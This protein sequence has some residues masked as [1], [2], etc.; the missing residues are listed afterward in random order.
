MQ[1]EKLSPYIKFVVALG[2]FASSVAVGTILP[3][4]FLFFMTDVAHVSPGLAGTVLLFARL[5]D[6]VNDP[7]VGNLS[8]RTHSRWGRRRPYMLFGAVPTGILFALLWI[9]PPFGGLARGIYYL[10]TYFLFDAA[11]TVVSGPYAA[12]TP[13]LTLDADER[14]S[15]ITWRMAVSI[16]TGLAAAIVM[17]IIFSEVPNLQMGFAVVGALVGFV[18]I[19]P[20]LWIVLAVRER[21]EF[22]EQKGV[23]FLEGLGFVVANRPFW[24]ALATDALA[25]VAIAI[26]EGVFA[27]FLIYWGG[28]SEEDSP[29]V[30]AAILASA[31]LFLPLVNWLSNH[32]EKKWAFVISTATWMVAHFGL[33]FVPQFMPAPIYIVAIVAGLGV[34]SAH[35]LPGAMSIDVLESVELDSGQRQ[36]GIFT[37]MSAFFRKLG[38]S[39]ALFALGWVLELTH[40]VP[41]AAEQS[42][43]ALTGIRV[44][45][46]WVP[47]ALL[48]LAILAAAAFPIT[49]AVHARMVAELE[50]RRAS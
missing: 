30:M 12:L 2:E 28:I 23:G 44:M 7:L 4:Y 36:E 6:A 5:W 14:T 22:Q 45:I 38:I 15:L 43:S 31:T 27:Y 29:L 48:G 40:Y 47:L 1:R 9:V 42:A 50:A 49:R 34:S 33:W 18:G 16:I 20:Y 25:W 17:G 26:V 10:V 19:F 46:T 32:F 35:V 13:E 24:L 39:A 11:F 37:G 21:P 3:F 41:N 8:D